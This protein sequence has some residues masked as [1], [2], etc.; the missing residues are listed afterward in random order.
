MIFDLPN[1]FLKSMRPE[2]R[3][4]FLLQKVFAS[5]AWSGLEEAVAV[6]HSLGP[7]SDDK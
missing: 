1:G 6:M 3:R 5:D 7:G 4:S 2:A